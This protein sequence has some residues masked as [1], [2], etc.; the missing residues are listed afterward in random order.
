MVA[1][2]LLRV[3]FDISSDNSS[4]HMEALP[5]W[6]G[7]VFPLTIAPTSLN[8]PPQKNAEEGPR[9]CPINSVAMDTGAQASCVAVAR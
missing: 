6:L 4:L 3:G 5:C 2:A 9:S 1:I 7:G 8:A